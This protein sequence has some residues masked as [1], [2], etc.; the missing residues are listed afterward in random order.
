MQWIINPFALMESCAQRY[1]DIFT[2]RV[3]PG[4]RPYVFVSNPQALQEILTNDTKQF[5]APGEVNQLFRPLLGH[6]GVV[7]QSGD[8]PVANANY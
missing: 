3:G 6:C 8:R 1:G 4:F 7:M 2:L 5:E